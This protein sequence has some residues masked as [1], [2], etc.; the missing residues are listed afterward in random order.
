MEP[1]GSLPC[2]QKPSTGP[3]HELLTIVIIVAYLPH[4]STVESRKPRNK[5]AAIEL[6]VLIARYEATV[7]APMNSLSGS[8]VTCPRSDILVSTIGTT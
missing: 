2:S 7:S 5:R 8:H 6:R 4:A 3:Y 1:E